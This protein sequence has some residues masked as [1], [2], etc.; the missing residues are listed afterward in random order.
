[1]RANCAVRVVGR[2]K[3]NKN[4]T[5][6]FLVRFESKQRERAGSGHKPCQFFKL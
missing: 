2:A 4:K 1:M 5:G 6:N 3:K